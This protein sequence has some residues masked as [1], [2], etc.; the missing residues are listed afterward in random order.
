MIRKSVLVF[1]VFFPL[2]ALADEFVPPC[3]LP[4]DA[5]KV[6]HPFDTKCGIGGTGTDPAKLLQNRVKNNF[7]AAGTPTAVSFQQLLTLQR[8]VE[9][10]AVL[11]PNYTEPAS[12]A[13]L[14]ARGEG[15][16]VAIVAFLK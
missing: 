16:P 6:K 12:R 10:P 9:S 14:V 3:T 7:C 11:G 13:R 4:F 5:I 8:Q 1:L 15:K 2:L